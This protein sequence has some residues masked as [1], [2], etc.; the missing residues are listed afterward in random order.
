MLSVGIEDKHADYLLEHLRPTGSTSQDDGLKCIHER[1]S[2]VLNDVMDI[3]QNVST[4]EGALDALADIIPEGYVLGRLK[5]HHAEMVASQWPR[6]HSWPNKEPYFR[7]LI[8]S[9]F[10]PAIYSLDNFEKPA[11]YIVQFP[12]NQTFGYT[13]EKHKGQHLVVVPGMYFYIFQLIMEGFFPLEEEAS[14]PRR[15][16]IF[17]KLNG[18]LSGYNVKDLATTNTTG[19]VDSKL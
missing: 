10:C 13:D 18:S 3:R 7:E 2:V 14:D 12:C 5:P 16:P 9:Y 15:V 8:K 6:L 1:I 19:I 4:L 17:T 11:S